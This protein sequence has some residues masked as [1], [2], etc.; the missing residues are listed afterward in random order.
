[1]YIWK[2]RSRCP[3]RLCIHS[4]TERQDALKYWSDV[5]GSENFCST[6]NVAKDKLPEILKRAHKNLLEYVLY[7]RTP[8]LPSY[9]VETNNGYGISIEWIVDEEHYALHFGLTIK[10]VAQKMEELLMVYKGNYALRG[11]DIHL[12]KYTKTEGNVVAFVFP[13]DIP[14]KRIRFAME[15]IIELNEAIDLALR[16][17]G[18]SNTNTELQYSN[19]YRIHEREGRNK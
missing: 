16:L 10:D 9:L 15:T 12:F 8:L 3:A 5:I 13:A 19:K 7:A 1:M 11:S 4:H 6:I 18:A 17:E 14:T 2:N